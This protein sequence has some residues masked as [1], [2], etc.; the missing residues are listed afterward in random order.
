[1][2]LYK[3]D[4]RELDIELARWGNGSNGAPNG[5]FVNQPGNGPGNKL[6]WTL[7]QGEQR[8]E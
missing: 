3:N 6:F 2:F 4:T 8:V 1:M 7:P 5:D